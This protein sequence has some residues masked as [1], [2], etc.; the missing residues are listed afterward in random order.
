MYAILYP[1]FQQN[2]H[3][4]RRVGCQSNLKQIGLAYVQ[5]EQ[6]YD[7][8]LPPGVNA[9]G[10]GWAEQ[11]YMYIKSSNV[12]RCPEDAHDNSFISYAENQNIARTRLYDFVDP[13]GTVALYEFT[14]LNCAPSKLETVSATGLNA[15]QNSPRHNSQTFALNFLLADGH[16]KHL[17]PG[18]VSG[19][20]NAV[21]P[22]RKGGYLATFA[23]K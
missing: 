17:S 12:Y 22:T 23:V 14:T 7:A 4:D 3:I 15:P 16:V 19:G 10:N 18:Q 11:L 6:D 9:K 8:A 1:V 5:Y 21:P 2:P 20:A 13:P